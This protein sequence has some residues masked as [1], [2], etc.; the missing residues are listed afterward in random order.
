MPNLTRFLREREGTAAVEFVLLMPLLLIIAIGGMYLWSLVSLQN[1]LSTSAYRAARYLS[2]EGYYLDDWQGEGQPI[3]DRFIRGEL[4]EQQINNIWLNNPDAVQL[5]VDL[6]D[7]NGGRSKP[8]C[9]GQTGGAGGNPADFTFTVSAS[10]RMPLP[11]PR[12][13]STDPNPDQRL[14]IRSN[15]VSFLECGQTELSE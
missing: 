10:L 13:L 6:L 15:H 4:Q 9:A 3:A 1:T 12:L 8:E 5:Q 11:L 2:V 14:T 7:S